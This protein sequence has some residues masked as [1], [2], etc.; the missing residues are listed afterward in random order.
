M[1]YINWMK[2]QRIALLMILL[3][4]FTFTGGYQQA[5]AR[6][7]YPFQV[8]ANVEWVSTG[9]YF[10]ASLVPLTLGIKATGQVITA[11][12]KLYPGAKSG[13]AGQSAICEDVPDLDLFCALAGYPF[14]MLIGKIG[15]TGAPFPIGDANSLTI[16]SPG[17][18]YLAVND[19]LGTY[20]DNHGQFGVLVK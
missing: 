4:A 19:Y 15:S 3:A 5:Q 10:D 2:I 7:T 1:K 17:F 13:P 8:P 9:V 11:P 20:F 6:A 14:G 18:L 16:A 12:I